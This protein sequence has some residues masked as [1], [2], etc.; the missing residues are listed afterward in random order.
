[1]SEKKAEQLNLDEVFEDLPF[2]ILGSFEITPDDQVPDKTAGHAVLLGNIGSA[3]FEAFADECDH[4][5]DS[6][7]C[8][9][10]TR[11][12][13]VAE[14]LRA[15][16]YFPFSKPALPFQRWARRARAGFSSPLGL[17]IHPEW[18]LWHGYR[19]LLVF[20]HSVSVSTPDPGP[21]PCL[22]CADRP[23]LSACPVEAFDGEAYD[24][25]VCGRHL[26]KKVSKACHNEGCLARLACPVGAKYRYN[27]DQMQFHMTA[28]AHSIWSGS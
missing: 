22:S 13:P 17:N 5:T 25:A 20:D 24:V 21:A 16:I 19:A 28:F 9:T 10:R 6:L 3:M 4:Q 23:C 11:L 14:Y 8:W 26:M 18:G 1:M 15:A 7:D 12:S 27:T 2:D